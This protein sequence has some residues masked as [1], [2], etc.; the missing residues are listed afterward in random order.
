MLHSIHVVLVQ[1]LLIQ[2]A[3]DYSENIGMLDVDIPPEALEQYAHNPSVHVGPCLSALHHA[4]WHRSPPTGLH[5]LLHS[6][7]P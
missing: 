2:L 1:I 7:S 3:D 5:V 4:A 6:L